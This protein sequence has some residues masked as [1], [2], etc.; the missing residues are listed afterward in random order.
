MV[1]YGVLYS[2]LTFFLIFKGHNYCKN[3]YIHVH[4]K[5]CSRILDKLTVV[6]LKRQKKTEKE[7]KV[8]TLINVS[9]LII[10]LYVL[11]YLFSKNL[12]YGM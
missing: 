1:L 4:K 12:T 7:K 8:V 5:N 9:Q 2:C 11:F 3:A 10:F 6:I